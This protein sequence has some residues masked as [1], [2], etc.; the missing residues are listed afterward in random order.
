MVGIG[1]GMRFVGN[2][3]VLIL[4]LCGVVS[5]EMG[6]D[7]VPP[8]PV[9]D[10]HYSAPGERIPDQVVEGQK[11]TAEWW[12]LFGSSDLNA[13]IVAALDNNRDVAAAKASLAQVQQ[14]AEAANGALYP[15]MGLH[16]GAVREKVNFTS[17]GMN[18]PPATLNLFSVGGTVSYALDF[19]GH[20]RRMAEAAAS[21][22]DAEAFRLNGA[23]LSLTGNVVMQ[24]LSAALLDEQIKLTSSVIELDQKEVDLM[25]TARQAGTVSDREMAEAEARLAKDAALRPPLTAQ[26]SGARHMLAVLVGKSPAEWAA[27]KFN[28]SSFVVPQQIPVSLPSELVHQR[29]DIQAAEADL[30]AANALVG[31]AE[32]SRYPRIVLSADVTQWA[33]MPSQMW[34]NL[35]TG[36]SGGTGIAAPLFQG[37]QLEAE[38]RA[39]ESA[40]QASFA[41][42]Q[43]IVLQS[44]A[45]VAT[46]LQALEQDKNLRQQTA[47]ALR[48]AAASHGYAQ[49]ERQNGT[50]GVFTEIAAERQE[51][52]AKMADSQAK[53]VHLKDCA[54]L[55]LSMGGGWWN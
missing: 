12:R 26:L 20:D 43:Q 3:P 21:A 41:H 45:Q 11:V 36:A 44:F 35:A 8:S 47:L 23:Y 37:G 32:A 48:A 1:N 16:G 31:V 15:Q 24:A 38:Q 50:V 18:F 7:F 22:A 51:L 27:P 54:E 39:A 55:Y 25:R 33:T 52:Q 49:L 9:E 29:P 28:L 2:W 53:A 17:Y 40:Y 4:G 19:F 6:P 46:V 5:C 42:Y 13:M 14:R 34:R 30:H 10:A